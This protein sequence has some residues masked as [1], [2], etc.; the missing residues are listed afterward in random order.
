MTGAIPIS[1]RVQLRGASAPLKNRHAEV[2]RLYA[3]HDAKLVAAIEAGIVAHH[4]IGSRF[5]ASLTWPGG[6]VTGLFDILEDTAGEELDCSKASRLPGGSH[7]HPDKFGTTR[8]KE[9]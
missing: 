7:R 2:A 3:L 4:A 6:N 1:R 8:A 5:G 9:L